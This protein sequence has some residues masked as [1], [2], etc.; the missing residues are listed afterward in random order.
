MLGSLD[1]LMVPWLS[2]LPF[3]NNFEEQPELETN[4]LYT[5]V[6]HL[7][8]SSL[9]LV[10]PALPRRIVFWFNILAFI[11][12]YLNIKIRNVTK[13]SFLFL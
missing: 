13:A 4:T 10:K 11:E 5:F 12:N 1:R 6:L 8:N 3:P 7:L 2:L 9:R